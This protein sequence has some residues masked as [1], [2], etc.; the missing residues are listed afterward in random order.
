MAIRAFDQL[1]HAV[2]GMDDQEAERALSALGA[3]GLLGETD[4][5]LAEEASAD[6]IP[7]RLLTGDGHHEVHVGP[8]QGH[9][10]SGRA[11]VASLPLAQEIARRWN[12]YAALVTFVARWDR[13]VVGPGKVRRESLKGWVQ[14]FHDEATAV[15]AEL[16]KR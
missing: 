3:L 12:A 11:D 8:Y 4:A 7:A 9:R 5:E 10:L 13:I 16:R 15:L 2:R 6:P 1:S 14:E